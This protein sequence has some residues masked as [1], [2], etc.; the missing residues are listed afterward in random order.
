MTMRS[1]LT[2]PPMTLKQS[3][4][5]RSRIF[6]L[7][8]AEAVLSLLGAGIAGMLW[9][10]GRH[11]VDLPC[12][13]DGLG[14]GRVEGSRWSHINFGG[15]H[16]VPVALLG[17]LGFLA[18]LSLAFL[19]LGVSRPRLQ[20][21]LHRSMLGISALGAAYSLFLQSVAHFQ[22]HAFC[23]WCFSSAC[24]MLLI[25]I[26]A[27][28]ESRT[29]GQVTQPFGRDEE[30]GHWV[31]AL[32]LV[33]LWA[34]SL[35]GATFFVRTF[36]AARDWSNID[37][38][39]L[40]S[41]WPAVM[42]HA[43][44]APRGAAAAPYTL[45][46]FGDFQCRPCGEARPV[47]EQLLKQY[48]SQVNLVF[49][50]RP[51]PHAHPWALPAA[52][53]SQI[54]AGRGKFWPMYDMLYMHQENLNPAMYGRYAAGIGLS[55]PQFAAAF[56]SHR[57]QAQVTSSARFADTFRIFATP[58]LLL[59]DNRSGAVRVYVG[60]GSLK[61]LARNPPWVFAAASLTAKKLPL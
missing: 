59:R 60:P 6:L 31:R 39:K 33:A 34:A 48:P 54:A 27:T 7:T 11:D 18:L 20:T 58:T 55:G 30:P 15:G 13:G 49:V 51:I 37:G 8:A 44:S 14:C 25:F 19:K 42:A 40:A 4:A 9:W 22:I 16:P 28:W 47:L 41:Q 5:A 45:V 17:L 46:E 53:A 61:R 1:E 29:R 35:G 57:Y 24:A 26:L 12:T 50:H 43:A 10:S 32:L 2:P 21:V 3:S 23:I 36:V 56:Q 38:A 52:E